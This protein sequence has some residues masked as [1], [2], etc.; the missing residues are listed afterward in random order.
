M[1]EF[2]SQT[3]GRFTYVDDVLNLQE[4]ALAICS[5]FDG[6]DNFIV[7]GCEVSGST[8]TPGIVYLNGKLRSFTGATDIQSW[9]Q[10]IYEVNSTENIPYQSGGEKAGRNIWGCAIGSVVPTTITGLTDSIPQ[11]IRIASTGGLRLKDAWFGK[12]AILREA[13]ATSQSAKGT[14]MV[15]NLEATGDVKARTKIA[16]VTLGGNAQM[17]YDGSNMIV[18]SV[19][20]NG[21]TKYRMV[22]SH[23]SGG[24]QFY[25]NSTL[26]ATLTD[27]LITF[28]QPINV[29]KATV[30]SLGI[31]SANLYNTSTASD[32]GELNINLIGYKG[33][34][35]YYRNTVIGNGKGA[36]LISVN[37]KNAWVDMFTG[38]TLNSSAETGIVLKSNKSKSD[39]S[40]R[41]LISWQD[42]TDNEMAYLGYADLANS[43]FKLYNLL[44]AIQIEGVDFVNIA[45]IIQEN[46]Q[47]LSEKYVLKTTFDT[48]I[49]KKVDAT[50]VYTQTECN[51]KFAIK[52]GGL[53]QF[54][55]D[56]KSK[57]TLCSE[58]GA[59]TSRD[60]SGYPTLANCLSD[61]AK[62]ENAKKKIR[63]NIGAAGAGDYQAKLT[64]TGWVK[65]SATLY[66]RQI[67]DIVSIQGTLSTIHSGTVF[68]LP[69]NI[70][71][72]RYAVGYDAPMTDGCYWSCR[73][74]GGKKAC[75]V[76]RC[77]HHG[78]TVPICI[79]YMT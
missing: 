20:D 10:F 41:K 9:P 45:P 8:I 75:T 47:P 55:T 35:T 69:N 78:M 64:D 76:T 4:L 21:A 17:Y 18:E 49:K 72:P 65:I 37:G 25:K 53:A 34:S 24:F 56:I 36:K 60:L 38:L 11:S 66:A 52:N 48:S 26:L 59:L 79:T 46:G 42:S 51:Q 74:D 44:G 50:L 67:G 31:S 6:C 54:I 28:A 14:L 22:A 23:G 16:L 40:L 19:V 3:G 70:T 5:I 63:D 15:E 43:I 2:S 58:I 32:N 77:N 27:T 71:A 12:Y 33:A 61:M 1:K 39:A 29:S 57:D 13:S 68:T 7:S 73:I 62:D 30:G